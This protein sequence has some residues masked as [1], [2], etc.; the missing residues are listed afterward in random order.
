MMFDLPLLQLLLY[1]L[2]ITAVTIIIIVIL[3]PP[4]SKVWV[5][6]W[7]K[8]T[9]RAGWVARGSELGARGPD[10]RHADRSRGPAQPDGW[11]ADRSGDLRGLDGSRAE[12]GAR[13]TGW[14]ACGLDWMG[15]LWTGWT[16]RGP[17]TDWH[18]IRAGGSNLV[19]SFQ[20]RRDFVRVSNGSRDSN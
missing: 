13:A 5:L 11:H 3:L 7:K 9:R 20:S 1:I 18:G 16:Q 2:L 8:G 6:S 17:R 14:V 19:T 4:N 15:G 12:L 10:G